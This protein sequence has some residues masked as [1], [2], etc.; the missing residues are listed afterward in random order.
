MGFSW[1]EPNRCSKSKHRSKLVY[2]LWPH[3]GQ[4][5]KNEV[6]SSLDQVMRAPAS[7]S[8][9]VFF[10][11]VSLAQLS[12]LAQATHHMWSC[13]PHSICHPLSLAPFSVSSWMGQEEVLDT[14]PASFDH[15]TTPISCD[16][17]LTLYSTKH[18]LLLKPRQAE[19]QAN[20]SVSFPG[21]LQQIRTNWVA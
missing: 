12:S 14:F 3:F 17:G 8:E 13:L 21:L 20:F 16:M 9:H 7:P 11:H 15:S 19:V 10:I 4:L 6:F 1:S 5:E 18:T 2:L